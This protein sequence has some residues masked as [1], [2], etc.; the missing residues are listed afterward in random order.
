MDD[1]GR[2][3][4]TPTPPIFQLFPD[5]RAARGIREL[6]RILASEYESADLERLR[7]AHKAIRLAVR[8]YWADKRYDDQQS[9]GDAKAQLRLFQPKLVKFVNALNA[10]PTS[11][12]HIVNLDRTRMTSARQKV[13]ICEKTREHLDDL[14]DTINYICAPVYVKMPEVSLKN[15]CTS[16]MN[17][18]QILTGDE[19]LHSWRLAKGAGGKLEFI[20]NDA[21]FIQVAVE[22]IDPDVGPKTLRSTLK[23]MRKQEGPGKL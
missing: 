12:R 22:A 13:N 18:R 9:Y 23:Q 8:K 5:K 21:R 15:L 7:A 4:A 17:V 16:L 19:F 3:A 14:N 20:S 10:L 11:T 2:L 1:A 6:R